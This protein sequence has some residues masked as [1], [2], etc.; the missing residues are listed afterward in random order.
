MPF[1]YRLGKKSPMSQFTLAF[2][3]AGSLVLSACGPSKPDRADAELQIDFERHTLDNGLTVLI[4]E[5]H[6]DPVVH[7]DVTYHVGSARE[8]LGKSGFA[9]LFE[10]MMF[11]GSEHVDDEEHIKTITEAGG[12]M[13]G[14]TNRDRTNYFET[15]P[16]NQLETVLWLEADR[17]GFFLPAIT[18]EKFEIQRATVKN[19]KQQNYGNRPYGRTF[20]LITKALYPYGHP[21]SWLTIGDL[22]DLDRATAEDL[23]NF[24]LRWYGPNNA[25]L[26]IGGDVDPEQVMTLV[27]KYFGGIER[28]P[29]VKEAIIPRAALD[30]DRYLSYLDSNIRFP[31]VTLSFPTVPNFHPDAPALACLAEILGAG[32]GSYLYQ[33]LVAPRLAIQASASHNSDELAGEF[34]MFVLPFPGQS[35]PEF[36]RLLRDNLTSFEQNGVSD[37][38]LQKFKARYES[39]FVHSLEKVSGK[40]SR[41]AYYETFAK[42]AAYFNEDLAAHLAVTREDVMR[43][44]DQYIKNRPAVIV[45]VLDS[46]DTA[47]AQPDNYTIPT[48]GDS[49]YPKA[50]YAGLEYTPA[51]DDFDRSVKPAPGLAKLVSP[52]DYWKAEADNGLRIIGAETDELPLVSIQLSMVGGTVTDQLHPQK[53]GMAAFTAAMMNTSTEN[54]SERAIAEE[55]EKLGSYIQFGSNGQRLT[56]ELSSLHKNLDATLALLQEKLFRPAF[57]Q[58]DFERVQNQLIEGAKS[59][60]SSADAI[61]GMVYPSLI[62]G[63]KHPLGRPE[64]DLVDTYA[65]ISMGDLRAYYARF[66]SPAKAELVVV[67]DI[68]KNTALKKLR[69]LQEWKKPAAAAVRLPDSP[70]IAKTTVFLIDKPGAAQSVIKIGYLSQL[71]YSATGEYYQRNLMNFIYGGNFNSRINLNLREDKGISYGV[72]S[73]FTATEIPGPFTVNAPVKVEGTGLALSEILRE[74]DTMRE[75]PIRDEELDFLKKA[76]GQRDA[77]KYE[78]NGQ[79]A[80]F[81]EEI[82]RFNIDK[83]F[84]DERRDMIEALTKADILRLAQQ[85]LPT[86]KL[87][88]LVVGDKQAIY[89]DLKA[90][91]YPIVELDENGRAIQ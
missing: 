47:P 24:F 85:Y 40:V 46:A 80:E 7:V 11:Q 88:I 91:G 33:S 9:H 35:L 36:E 62:Y 83:N 89:E 10:H 21:Y 81:L 60:T 79:K 14:T 13:N 74:M 43:V 18:Q 77:L 51:K 4:H 17:M 63:A 70:E 68:D 28:G 22:E 15:V 1:H 37:E 73:Y 38:D 12:S 53:A 49:P 52:P 25:T 61:A 31:A 57:S 71:P 54:Y 45:S 66:F 76:I 72:Y 26:T 56:V 65:R 29:Q 78:S 5:D 34:F 58:E 87:N 86:D 6:S 20:E 75:L 42:D 59:S 82:L 2:C 8:E 84:T 64:I 30:S 3:L 27:K 90:L 23:K 39:Q 32:K 50:N 41:L 19:E 16:A 67:G 48:Q 55:L 69:F 44:Y